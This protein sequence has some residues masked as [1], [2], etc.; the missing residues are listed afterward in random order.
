[1]S[2]LVFSEGGVYVSTYAGPYKEGADQRKRV[3][4]TVNT[5]VLALTIEQW[6]SLHAAAVQ[7][8]AECE[9][10]EL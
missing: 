2:V 1:M 5:Q 9:G 4:V 10:D 6:R 7:L 3:Q 8:G